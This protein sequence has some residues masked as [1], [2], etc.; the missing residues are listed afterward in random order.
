MEVKS[1]WLK[2]SIDRRYAVDAC[3]GCIMKMQIVLPRHEKLSRMFNLDM[4][5]RKQQTGAFIIREM[6]GSRPRKSEPA[7]V[8]GLKQLLESI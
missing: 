8:L 1:S 3:T 4:E 2:I 7:Q 5:T 6:H